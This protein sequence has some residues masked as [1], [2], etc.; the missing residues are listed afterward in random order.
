MRKAE[1]VERRRLSFTTPLPLIAVEGV[2][3]NRDPYSDC[4]VTGKCRRLKPFRIVALAASLK[5]CP[6]TNLFLN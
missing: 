2:M 6:D 3:S 1:K 4:A 5:R